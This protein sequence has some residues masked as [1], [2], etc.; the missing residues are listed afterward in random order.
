MS[1][2]GLEP[3]LLDLLCRLFLAVAAFHSRGRLLEI[4]NFLR[5]IRYF[6]QYLFIFEFHMTIYWLSCNLKVYLR[7]SAK[8][9]LRMT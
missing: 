9:F 7:R 1:C 2:R 8:E 5:E 6:F 3:R 4:S